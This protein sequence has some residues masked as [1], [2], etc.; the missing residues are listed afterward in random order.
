MNKLLALS[1]VTIVLACAEVFAD[2]SLEFVY[3]QE[4]VAA[5]ENQLQECMLMGRNVDLPSE[6]VLSALEAYPQEQVESFLVTKATLAE[7]QC[8]AKELGELAAALL[9]I[10]AAEHEPSEDAVTLMNEIK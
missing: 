10:E 1:T 6:A 9:T 4:K 2:D 8:V 5:Y 7:E 3:L